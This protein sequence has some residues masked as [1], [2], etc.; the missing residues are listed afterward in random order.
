MSESIRLGLIGENIA[1]SRS[2]DIFQAIFSVTGRSGEFKIYSVLQA[3][4]PHTIE[5]LRTLPLDGLAVTVPFKRTVISLLDELDAVSTLLQAVNCIRFDGSFTRGFNTDVDGF[6]AG[7]Q[8]LR[9]KVTGCRALILGAGGAASAA[10][11]SLI[12]E[13]GVREIVVAARPGRNLDLLTNQFAAY[14]DVAFNTFTLDS[15][16]SGDYATC[17][18]IVN[19]TPLG[20]WHF[21]EICPL[22]ASFIWPSDAVYYDMNYNDNGIGVQIAREAGLIAIDGSSMLVAQAIRSYEIWTGVQSPFEPV[23]E[24]CFGRSS[25]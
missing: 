22:P 12:H 7:L 9:A 18:L 6:A 3:D 16:E 5:T 17:G 2:P 21:P 15:L 25:R 4:L 23:Y 11:Y 20:G 19:C 10:I 8:P 13:F 14:P 1:Y 24:A